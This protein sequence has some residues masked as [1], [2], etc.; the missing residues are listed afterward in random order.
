[1]LYYILVLLSFLLMLQNTILEEMTIKRR[2]A[3]VE[4][5][6]ACLHL[7]LWTV[8]R[9]QGKVSCLLYGGQDTHVCHSMP[10]V[11]S[12][13]TLPLKDSMLPMVA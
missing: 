6:N 4:P 13:K 3:D 11:Y 12:H 10:V 7:V 1:M 8:V 9:E 2:K 5:V